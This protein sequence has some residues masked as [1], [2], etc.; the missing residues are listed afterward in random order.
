MPLTREDLS[1]IV[2]TSILNKKNALALQQKTDAQFVSILSAW[3]ATVNARLDRDLSGVAMTGRRS[4]IVESPVIINP[5]VLSNGS[6]VHNNKH[7]NNESTF[8]AYLK[9]LYDPKAQFA[10]HSSIDVTEILPAASSSATG[11]PVM[12]QN[13]V[14]RYRFSW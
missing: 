4:H 14:F 1:G 13:V 7:M 12:P 3:V 2:H 8:R 5:G 11:V 6:T 9:G 10:V